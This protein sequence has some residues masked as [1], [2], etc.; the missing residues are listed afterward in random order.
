M[1]KFVDT[2]RDNKNELSQVLY[3]IFL[4]LYLDMINKDLG[5]IGKFSIITFKFEF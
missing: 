5:K 4:N 1:S 3:P 2:T